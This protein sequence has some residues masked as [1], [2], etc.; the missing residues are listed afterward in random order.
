[1]ADAHGSSGRGEFHVDIGV[2]LRVHELQTVVLS[3]RMPSF[4]AIQFRILQSHEANAVEGIQV[5]NVNF[6]SNS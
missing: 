1:M 2:S 6:L 4:P 5:S 3:S